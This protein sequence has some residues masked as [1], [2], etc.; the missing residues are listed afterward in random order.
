MN[1]IRLSKEHIEECADLFIDVFTKAPWNDTYNSKGQVISYFQNYINNNY[2][3][4][5]GLK[6]Q[7]CMIA[8]SVGMKKPWIN[9]MEYYIDQFCVKTDLQGKGIGSYFLKLIEN[10]IQTEKMF[11]E[12]VLID[13]NMVFDIDNLKGFLNDTS[14]FG[15]IAKENNKI[16]G[17]AY[18]YTLLR[19]DGKTMFYLH[20][21]GMLPNYQ[22][23]GYGSKLLSFIKEYSKEIGCSEMFLITDKGNPR[24]CHVYEKLGGKNDYK[25][26]IVYVY[27][28]EKGDK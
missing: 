28:Y 11:M 18:C 2:F 21:I 8:I 1:I 6:D 22:D 7:N 3:V 27:D 4:G 15:F 9:G 17:F 10:E 24:A 19:P 14:S 23:K 16:I 20:S 13:D 12:E 25:D 5:Y 26:E